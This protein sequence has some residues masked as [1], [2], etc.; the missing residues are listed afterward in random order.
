MKWKLFVILLIMKVNRVLQVARKD[1]SWGIVICFLFVLMVSC[2]EKDYP[3]YSNVELREMLTIAREEG[4]PFCVVVNDSSYVS[5]VYDSLLANQF[6]FMKQKALFNIVNKNAGEFVWL[7]QLVCTN[8]LPITIVFS[9]Q[10]RIRTILA[11]ATKRCFKYIDLAI[12]N[13]ESYMNYIYDNPFTNIGDQELISVLNEILDC[14]LRLDKNENIDESIVQSL[15]V[16]Q[17]PFN[18]YL[19]MLNDI[20]QN[21]MDAAVLVAKQLWESYDMNYFQLYENVLNKARYVID[22]EYRVENEPKLSIDN[23]R[24]ILNDCQMGEKQFFQMEF[25]NTGKKV[26]TIHEIRS[27]CPCVSLVDDYP[28]VIEPNKKIIVKCV[29]EAISKGKMKKHLTILSNGVIPI[30]NVEISM[31]VK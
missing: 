18:F 10:G 16:I 11:G 26:L 7:R 21:N 25:T 15:S 22:P 30:E 6:R 12:D 27:C 31:N 5:V 20:K 17:Y 3:T 28:S 2:N 4:K 9:P 13:D 19:K 29:M 1:G 23:R 8:R 24:I 14:K